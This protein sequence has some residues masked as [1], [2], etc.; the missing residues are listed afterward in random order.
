MGVCGEVLF[1][2]LECDSSVN[3]DRML[4][5]LSPQ[6]GMDLIL[7]LINQINLPVTHPSICFLLSWGPGLLNL[8]SS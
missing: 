2:W 7:R 1:G 5:P 4:L 8:I 3:H 6:D